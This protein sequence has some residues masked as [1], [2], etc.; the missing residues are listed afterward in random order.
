[1][2]VSRNFKLAK[3]VTL[4]NQRLKHKKRLIKNLNSN[5]IVN[6]TS[7]KYQPNTKK[8]YKPNITTS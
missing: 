6:N 5:A 3:L 8:S 7:A 1:M 4:T 2:Q